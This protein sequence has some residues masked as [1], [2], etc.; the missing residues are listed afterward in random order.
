VHRHGGAIRA[1]AAPGRGA[2]FCFM[3]PDSELA[4]EQAYA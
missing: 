2:T 1:E 4:A 3:L